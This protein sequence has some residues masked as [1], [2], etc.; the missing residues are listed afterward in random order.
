MWDKVE[1]LFGQP[2]QKDFKVFEPYDGQILNFLDALSNEILKIENRRDFPD[3]VSFAFYIRKSNLKSKKDFF[4]DN[5]LR[6]GRGLVFHIAPSNVPLNFAFS[7]VFALLSGNSNIIRISSRNFPQVDL[8][9]QAIS[10][11]TSDIEFHPIENFITIIRYE[12][13]AAITD[14]FS[15]ICAARV[16]WGGNN[17]IRTIKKSPI[18]VR[19]IDISFADRKSLTVID[20]KSIE[21]LSNEAL[22]HLCEQFF[23]D[24]YLFDQEGC[25]SP[26][27]V[28]WLNSD[29]HQGQKSRFWLE[30]SKIAERRYDLQP[31]QAMNKFTELCEMAIDEP[32]DLKVDFQ[33]NYLYRIRSTDLPVLEQLGR[34]GTFW[35][36]DL[37]SVAE[38]AQITQSDTQ[39]LT[40]FGVSPLEI[41]EE[42]K[43]GKID[44]IDRVVPIGSAFEIDTVWDGNDLIRTLSR[45]IAVK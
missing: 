3:L 44:G 27:A 42:L 28:I 25:S 43:K 45:I 37:R 6:L 20:A 16:I 22:S 32:A 34:Y 33:N 7:M 1:I 10:K 4:T 21:E 39:T 12:H 18:P 14:Y 17:T 29:L 23:T 26:K 13:N 11:V 15:S 24:V 8:L 38:L 9:I 5:E 35:E 2:Q 40:Y 36:F 30:L 31:M 19:S 41:V